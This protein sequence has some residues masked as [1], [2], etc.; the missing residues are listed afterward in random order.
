[1][2]DVK[3]NI[4]YPINSERR[5]PF[6]SKSKGDVGLSKVPNLSFS[7]LNNAILANVNNQ[8]N[9]GTIYQL[10]KSVGKENSLLLSLNLTLPTL[11]YYLV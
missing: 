6:Y 4:N 7:E 3:D 5:D 2:A 9:E 1:M 11:I 10:D 8:V